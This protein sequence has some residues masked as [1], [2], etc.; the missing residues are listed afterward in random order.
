MDRFEGG[1][2][3]ILVLTFLVAA[4][5]LAPAAGQLTEALL[6]CGRFIR[7]PPGARWTPC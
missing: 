3:L 7:K 1:V 4:P 6:A 5:L 2:R